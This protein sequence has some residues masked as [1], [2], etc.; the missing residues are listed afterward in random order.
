MKRKK[1]TNVSGIF[2]KIRRHPVF[3]RLMESM[4][5]AQDAVFRFPVMPQANRHCLGY[6]IG[7]EV[8]YTK[9]NILLYGLAGLVVMVLDD[10]VRLTVL[11]AAAEAC[12]LAR[13]LAYWAR[14]R[15]LRRALADMDR[16][17]RKITG[18]LDRLSLSGYDVSESQSALTEEY[19]RLDSIRL[20]AKDFRPGSRFFVDARALRA[21]CAC[22]WKLR[23]FE[24][25]VQGAALPAVTDG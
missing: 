1:R 24:L 3:A 18:L 10:A 6:F 14:L 5:R 8:S 12:F 2:R 11:V 19:E 25:K 20:S 13:S 23:K 21:S 16:T 4:D 17:F 15:R 7:E 9:T 22:V